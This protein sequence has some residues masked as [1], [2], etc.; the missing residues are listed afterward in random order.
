MTDPL[1]LPADLVELQRRLNTARAA[2]ADYCQRKADEYRKHYPAREQYLERAKWTQEE[3]S[4]LERLRAAELALVMAVHRHP[5][6]QRALAEGCAWQ[7]EQAL[8]QAAR[9]TQAPA[10]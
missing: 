1:S 4:E 2:T 5:T 9:E 3:S 6:T 8:K 7:T 10:A